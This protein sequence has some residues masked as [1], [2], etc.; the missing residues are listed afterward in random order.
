MIRIHE[1]PDAASAAARQADA[2]ADVLRQV[3]RERAGPVALALSGGR[4]PIPFFEAL[5]QTHLDWARVELRLVDERLVAPDHAHSNE[6]LLRDHLCQAH[7]AAARCIGLVPAAEQAIAEADLHATALQ[8]ANAWRAPI[9]LA[10]LGMGTDGHIASLFPSAPTYADATDLTASARYAVLRPD[11]ART[12]PPLPRIS[13]TLSALLAARR[14]QLAISSATKRGVFE[15]AAQAG[16]NAD[17][18][19]SLLLAHLSPGAEF[20]VYWHP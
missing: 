1:F 20:D 18:P 7:A 15:R 17:L 11:P 13:L 14:W 19:I 2:A 9:D 16:A 4:S 10:V 3:L 5:R 8:R 12:D 6:R